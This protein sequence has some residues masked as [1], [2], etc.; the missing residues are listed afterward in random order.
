MYET[1]GLVHNQAVQRAFVKSRRK[2]YRDLQGHV[3]FSMV[4]GTANRGM[5][6]L[7]VEALSTDFN[8]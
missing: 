8:L 6:A 3:K 7:M 5:Y 4:H 2:G 1:N